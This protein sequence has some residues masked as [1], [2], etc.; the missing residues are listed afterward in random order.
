M[1]VVLVQDV[2]KLGR[3]GEVI[4]VSDGYA[5]NFLIPRGLAK[6]ATE[7]VLKKLQEEKELERKRLEEQRKES[8]QLLSELQRHVF[9]IHAKAG[10]SGKLF[11]SLTANNIAE[12]ISKVTGKQVD[13]K[14][15]VLD[16]PIKSTGLYDVAVKLPG[17]VSGKIKVEVLPSEK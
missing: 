17:G 12:E 11:G 3:K 15:I 13:K 2:P 5:R 1:K 7:E 9:K 8:E 6:E 16:N 10:E 14:W 4:N